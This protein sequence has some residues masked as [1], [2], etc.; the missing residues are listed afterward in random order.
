MSSILDLSEGMRIG[1]PFR[2][3][4]TID[5]DEERFSEYDY[6]FPP[7]SGITLIETADEISPLQGY[8]GTAIA[9]VSSLNESQGGYTFISLTI[10][11]VDID[12]KLSISREERSRGNGYV[13]NLDQ[14]GDDIAG[15]TSTVEKLDRGF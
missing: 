12:G 8:Y 15:P 4:A 5:I 3:Q 10:V 14:H 11:Q 1:I 9:E 2:A 13:S 7:N 6:E